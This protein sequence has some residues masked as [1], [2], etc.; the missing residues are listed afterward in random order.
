MVHKV[1]SVPLPERVPLGGVQPGP[2]Q[3]RWIPTESAAVMWVEALDGGNPKE[4]VPHRDR[5]VALKA[6]FTGEPVEVFKTEERY[7]GHA[8]RQE[9]RADRRHGAR[10]HGSFEHSRSIRRNQTAKRSSSGA[11]T[12]RIDIRILA[13]R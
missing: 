7:S 6:P 11:A 9:L 4:K 10:F 3:F 8:V 2:R 5:V 1:A 13:G 12:L